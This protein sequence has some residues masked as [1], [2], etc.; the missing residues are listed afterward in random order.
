MKKVFLA[1]GLGLM[2]FVSLFLF[3]SPTSSQE[4]ISQEY[5]P[6]EVLVKF[7]P[8]AGQQ[9]ALAALDALK[10][11]VVNYLGQEIAFTDWN[12][13]LRVKSSF[14]GDPYL[15]HLRVPE[16]IG[17]EKAIAILK[18]NPNVEYAEPNYVYR[19][20]ETILNDTYFS[21]L[22]GLKNIG[23]IGGKPGADIKATLAW[24]IF[25]GS[26][27][28]VVAII[29]TGIDYNHTDLAQ[30]I[31]INTNEIPNNNIDDDGNGYVDDYHGYDFVNGDGDPMDDNSHGTHVAGIIGGCG[32]NGLGIVG[33]CWN[34]NL[35]ALKFLN[36]IGQGDTAQA[37]S[38]IDYA[39]SMG[40]KIINA[41]WGSSAYS[42]SLLSAI[43]RAQ[44]N[45]ILFIAAAGNAIPPSPPSNNDITP[46][47]PSSYELDNIIS[48]LSTDHQDNISGFSNYGFYSV[49]LGAPG[50][51]DTTQS[52]YNI[53]STIPSN[54]FWYLSGTS[55]ATPFVSGAA[56]LLL[57]LRPEIGWWQAKTIILKQVDIIDALKGKCET[58][59]RLNAFKTLT[60]S[61]PVL[62]TAPSDLQGTAYKNGD[63]YDIRLNWQDNSYNESGFKIYMKSGNVFIPIDQVGTDVTTY[64]LNEVPQGYY[65]FYLRAFTV[66]GES[67]R[68]LIKAI[69]AY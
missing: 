48:V 49:D 69:K 14:L 23:Q 50:G 32:N 42:D 35:M 46:H 40:A 22:W 10:P 45:G 25:T 12:P 39:I 28:V 64:W 17:T 36:K 51:S 38:A 47:Y 67:T 65:Y 11:R 1:L 58:S 4:T 27:D 30:N 66:D 7:K 59:G 8:E 57:G 37:V 34:V 56:A 6:N 20:M 44:A 61:I 43:G 54:K 29:D 26:S 52:S 53:Y 15:V 55:M 18:N 13:S 33:V 62:P 19:L 21:K 9:K 68:T 41:S 2:I 5:V 3:K 63:F 24:D 60:S 16:G 31:W